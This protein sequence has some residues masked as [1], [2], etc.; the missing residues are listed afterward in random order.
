LKKLRPRRGVPAGTD[1]CATAAGAF[2]F[3]GTSCELGAAGTGVVKGSA[4]VDVD[5]EARGRE[6]ANERVRCNAGFE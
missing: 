3:A 6:D 4:A 2:F 1:D 5:A